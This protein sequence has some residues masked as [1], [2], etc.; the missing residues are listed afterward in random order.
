M[1]TVSIKIGNAI[2][3][4]KSVN[5]SSIVNQYKMNKFSNVIESLDSFTISGDSKPAKLNKYIALALACNFTI[6]KQ[7][8]KNAGFE[9]V[10]AD[11]LSYNLLFTK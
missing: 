6:S 2:T 4:I 8:I 1:N 3:V 11:V 7:D 9:G 5:G 10:N